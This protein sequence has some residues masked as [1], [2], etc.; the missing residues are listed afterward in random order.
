[1]HPQAIGCR[2]RSSQLVRPQSTEFSGRDL[3]R[4]RLLLPAPLAAEHYVCR[5]WNRRGVSTRSDTFLRP[6]KNAATAPAPA[7]APISA[8]APPPDA[9]QGLVC[10]QKCTLVTVKLGRFR[11][12][13]SARTLTR[14]QGSRP[15]EEAGLRPLSRCCRNYNPAL[16]QCCI[17]FV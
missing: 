6:V 14:R 1:M 10:F 13:Y 7:P 15:Q 8:P 16:L 17:G 4:L 11:F 2:A 9:P 3:T 5:K 12:Y